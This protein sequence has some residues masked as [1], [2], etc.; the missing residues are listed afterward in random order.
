MGG[1]I[2]VAL[3]YLHHVQ[4]TYKCTL[5]GPDPGDKIP[6]M[7]GRWGA[8]RWLETA[9]CCLGR[10]GPVTLFYTLPLPSVAPGAGAVHWRQPRPSKAATLDNTGRAQPTQSCL[11]GAHTWSPWPGD[12]MSLM[13]WWGYLPRRR[14]D[15]GSSSL[16]KQRQDVSW[17]PC[18]H[19]TRVISTLA[20]SSKHLFATFKW[21]PHSHVMMN[22]SQAS[23]AVRAGYKWPGVSVVTSPD[24]RHWG[25]HCATF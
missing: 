22:L 3:N 20:A 5:Q 14:R 10:L 4:C 11:H 25:V 21:S 2:Y 24:T 8:L 16:L 13:G 19:K 15:L 18:C 1:G 17:D 9:L 7:C 23:Q 6:W 12:H